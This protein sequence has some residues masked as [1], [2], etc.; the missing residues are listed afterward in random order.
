MHLLNLL[1]PY[2]AEIDTYAQSLKLWVLEICAWFATLMDSRVGRIEMQK[3]VI[4]MRAD[5]RA[6]IFLK[7]V[8]RLRFLQS[9]EPA[10]VQGRA[11]SAPR[12]FRMVRRAL[13]A[14]KVLT[15]GIRLKT[16][17][18]FRRVLEDMDHVV[19]RAL[20]RRPR[21]VR[22]FGIVAIAP[23]ADE[24]AHLAFTH[25]PDAADTS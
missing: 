3:M 9:R 2:L 23:P 21:T 4:Q 20:A 22:R 11:P 8:A 14:M 5:L 13:P 12:G 6:L 1:R 10:A 16:L 24:A 15:R 18:D 17:A 7:M 25:T 19:E